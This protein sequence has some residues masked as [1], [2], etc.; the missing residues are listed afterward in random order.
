MRC[1]RCPVRRHEAWA[2]ALGLK[3]RLSLLRDLLCD[4]CEGEAPCKETSSKPIAQISKRTRLWQSRN[5]SASEE[6]REDSEATEATPTSRRAQSHGLVPCDAGDC[7]CRPLA[8]NHELDSFRGTSCE[9]CH[10]Q[11]LALTASAQRC[12]ACSRRSNELEYVLGFQ[13][14]QEAP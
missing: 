5:F 11:A 6:V 3:C 7:N 9:E 4:L 1:P 13:Y 14:F 2:W 12:A 10:K 8:A